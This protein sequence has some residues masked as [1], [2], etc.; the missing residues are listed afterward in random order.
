M[1]PMD[2]SFLLYGAIRSDKMQ[3]G[4]TCFTAPV[5]IRRYLFP[6]GFGQRMGPILLRGDTGLTSQS[7]Y[8]YNQKILGSVGGSFVVKV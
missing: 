1:V 6:P 2:V 7:F 4:K 3:G 5:A 8:R